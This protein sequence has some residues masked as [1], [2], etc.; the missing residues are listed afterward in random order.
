M[1]SGRHPFDRDAAPDLDD[2]QNLDTGAQSHPKSDAQRPSSNALTHRARRQSSSAR[3]YLKPVPDTVAPDEGL[4]EAVEDLS[5]FADQLI[6]IAERL[7][8]GAAAPGQ[9]THTLDR[10]ASGH[11]TNTA[12]T[13]RTRSD[14]LGAADRR[15]LFVQMARTA[16][17]R[18]RKRGAIFGDNGLFGEPAWDILLDLYIAHGE[19]KDVSVS[20]A[21]IGSAAPPTTG[22]RWLGLLAD[23]GLVEREHD[24]EDQRRVLVRLT[25]RALSAMD[26]YFSSDVSLYGDRRSARA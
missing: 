19:G 6:A 4:N 21:C 12:H 3:D 9:L 20:S 2:A 7:R 8:Q 22:L 26:D 10:S 14:P 11:S 5:P 13:H 15:E 18:R 25:E 16:Y 17:A 24:T 1:D 23:Q